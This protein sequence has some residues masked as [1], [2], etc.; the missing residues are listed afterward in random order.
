VLLSGTQ[1]DTIRYGTPNR[2]RGKPAMG[3]YTHALYG[4]ITALV[5]YPNQPLEQ[6]YKSRKTE[7]DNF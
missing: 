5:S 7:N 1:L 2:V 6:I 4:P 3:M